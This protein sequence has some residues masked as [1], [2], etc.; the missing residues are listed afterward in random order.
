MR[1]KIRGR[2]IPRIDRTLKERR[3]DGAAGRSDMAHRR[4]MRHADNRDPSTVGYASVIG[5]L[6][7]C[8][9][10]ELLG[11]DWPGKAD[12]SPHPRDATRVLQQ[13]GK[14]DREETP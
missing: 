13:D 6:G 11:H 12:G 5:R 14:Q 2:V 3:A 7:G 1:H 10:G 9:C 4:G 8:W